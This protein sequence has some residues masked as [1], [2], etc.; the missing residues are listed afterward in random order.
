MSK[1]YWW[2]RSSPDDPRSG[3]ADARHASNAPQ[4]DKIER[5]VARDRPTMAVHIEVASVGGGEPKVELT[6]VRKPPAN[7]ELVS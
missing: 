1:L 7:A 6:L 4:I 2:A 5:P 3:R